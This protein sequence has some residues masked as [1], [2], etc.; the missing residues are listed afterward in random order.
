M[1]DNK[2][3]HN[4]INIQFNKKANCF[5]FRWPDDVAGMVVVVTVLKNYQSAISQTIQERFT[6]CNKRTD[7][8]FRSTHYILQKKLIKLINISKQ[9]SKGM[10]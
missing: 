1:N 4:N 5:T 9:F 6:T 3:I 10:F 2:I 8:T 7:K